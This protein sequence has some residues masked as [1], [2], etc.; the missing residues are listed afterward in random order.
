MNIDKDIEIL[1]RFTTVEFI[2]TDRAEIT[3]NA[4]KEISLAIENV[5]R[6]LETYKN[7]IARYEMESKS[8]RAFCRKIRKTEKRNV[9]EFNQGREYAYIQFLNL[10]SGEQNWEHEGEYFEEVDQELEKW[11]RKEV[12]KYE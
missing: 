11:A 9:D 8:F 12:E 6:E 10:I 3:K 4:H 1:K 2:M 7:K 5:L